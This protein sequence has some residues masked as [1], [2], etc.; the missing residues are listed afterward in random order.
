MIELKNV[1][2]RYPNRPPILLGDLTVPASGAKLIVGENGSGKS[3]LIKAVLR[4]VG[5]FDG[6]ILIDGRDNRHMSRLDIAKAVTYLPQTAPVEPD[7]PAEEFIRQG[8]YSGGAGRFDEVAGLLE[9]E[10]LLS[11]SYAQLSGGQKQLCRIARATVARAR[12]AFLDEPDAFLSKRNRA[13]F[14]RLID[15]LAQS[16]SVLIV[17]HHDDLPY[18]VLREFD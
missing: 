11:Q 10:D 3:S 14:V 6:E 17:S 15:R 7:I 8:L 9:L 13:L 2:V 1:T 4:I 5:D 16:Q 12:Y 18:P